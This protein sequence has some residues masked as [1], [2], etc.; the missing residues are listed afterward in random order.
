M[1]AHWEETMSS[2]TI[3]GSPG[4]PYSLKV[5]AALRGKR[6]VH[7]WKMLDAASRGDIM[8][9]VRA[10]V[11]PVIERPDGTW[12]NDSTPFLLDLEAKG[13]GRP[14]LPPDPVQRFACLLIEDMADEWVTKAM[15]HYRW[16]YDAD[17]D[18]MSKWLIYD[19]M[20]SA[21]RATIEQTAKGIAERQIGRMALVGCTPETAPI[22][23]GSTRRLLGILDRAAT[24]GQHF[25]FG[26]RVSLA[27][28]SLYGQ[29]WQLRTDP[30]P[31]AMMRADFPYAFRWLEH[32]DDASGFDGAWT[33]QPGEAVAGLMA[34][35]GDTYLAFLAANES[36]LA[37]G[38]ETFSLD[39]DGARFSQGVFKYQTK[40]LAALR[41]EWT[42]L[43]EADREALS[44]LIGDGAEIL[45]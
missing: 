7:V 43:G 37:A 39:I 13:E 9:K 34:L 18:Q 11:I 32:V 36:A 29:L 38:E 19:N 24:S 10:P 31:A 33:E 23:E 41:D 28:V 3:H 20:P 21:D 4:S 16:F 8:S 26:G 22:I 44:S 35:A 40:C 30:T 6:I 14:L 15:F 45:G 17:A 12:T 25:L 1:G 27:D 42:K 2:F 5:R